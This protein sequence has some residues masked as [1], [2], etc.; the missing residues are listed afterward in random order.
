MTP[1]R[2]EPARDEASPALRPMPRI[3]HRDPLDRQLRALRKAF[4]RRRV[5][6]SARR[7]AAGPGYLTREWLAF[8]LGVGLDTLDR[9]VFGRGRDRRPCLHAIVGVAARFGLSPTYVAIVLA[10]DLAALELRRLR[11][12]A[13]RSSPRR[14]S[15]RLASDALDLSKAETRARGFIEQLDQ[16]LDGLPPFEAR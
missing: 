2:R 6:A 16:L 14:R 5:R 1:V 11:T 4:S 10:R 13:A 3:D 7:V 12:A 15:S 8:D 9:N